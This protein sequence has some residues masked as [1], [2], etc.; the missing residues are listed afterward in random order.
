MTLFKGSGVALVTPMHADGRV[1]LDKLDEL[2]DWHI[3]K[4]TDALIICGTTG[5]A[6]TL[7]DDEHQELLRHAVKHAAGRIPIIAGTGSNN[8]AHA[9]MMS[10]YAESIGADAVL[11][12]TPYYNKCTQKGLVEHYRAIA[13]NINIP[14]I[15]YNVPGR[16]GVNILPK[17]VAE[18]AKH[19]NIVALK[20]ASGDIAQCCEVARLVPEDFAIYSGND[21]MIVPLLSLGGIGVIS[22]LGNVIPTEVHDMVFHYLEG[23]TSEARKLQLDTKPLNNVL[24]SEVNP[25][26]VKTAMNFMGMG[27]GPLRLPLSEMDPH[28]ADVLK[29]ELKNFNLL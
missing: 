14:I 8:T 13:D 9:V 5:E 3:E 19:P 11:C 25:I 12:V 10:Q 28:N 27:V 4:K 29:T 24:F 18:L 7:E 15:L 22:V 17:T 1:N 2:I 23:R 6:S 26:P 21:D 20:E 16:T